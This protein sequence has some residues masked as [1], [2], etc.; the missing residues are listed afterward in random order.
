M[1]KTKNNIIVINKKY[2]KYSF[3]YMYINIRKQPERIII[4]CGAK[5]IFE[6]L[7]CFGVL[8]LSMK[9]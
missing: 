7:I 1:A 8:F 4:R 3:A 2:K 5:S 6:I 9:I